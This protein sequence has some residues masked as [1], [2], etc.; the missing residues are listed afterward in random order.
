MF[1]SKIKAMYSLLTGGVTGLLKYGLSAFN[2]KVLGKIT[3]KESAAKYL[4]D[5]KAGYAFIGSVIVNH[6]DDLS[7][8][9]KAA[10]DA[11]LAAMQ[12]LTGALEDF[13]VD[14]DELTRIVAKINACIDAWK[15]AK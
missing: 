10:A 8:A 2:E 11:T 7:P 15:A 5:V 13:E 12:E 14:Q 9:K 1:I 6:A 4:K 3:D